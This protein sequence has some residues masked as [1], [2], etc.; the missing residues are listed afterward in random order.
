M[1]RLGLAVLALV[2]ACSGGSDIKD[3]GSGGQDAGV[4]DILALIRENNGL[5][6]ANY[7]LRCSHCPC[8]AFLDVSEAAMQCQVEV[9]DDFPA[10]RDV[11]IASLQCSIA[12]A[13]QKQSCLGAATSCPEAEACSPPRDGGSNDCEN[14]PG[15]QSQAA[16]DY[17]ASVQQR[18]GMK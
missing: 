8:G 9:L 15:A 5:T 16:S 7:D 14:I 12:R 6:R 3:G 2:S 10:I 4:T 13:K 1:S 18:C 11:L 17:T